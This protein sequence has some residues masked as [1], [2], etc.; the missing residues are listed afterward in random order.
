MLSLGAVT[1]RRTDGGVG[2]SD[3]RAG[4]DTHVQPLFAHSANHDGERQLLVDHLRNVAALAR[5]RA[6]PFG[7]GDLAFLAGLWHDAGKADPEWQRYLLESEAGTRTRGSGP[8]HKSAGA[9]LAEDE[10]Q[11]LVGL[12]IQA[13]HGGLPDPRRDHGPWLNE[14]RARRGPVQA[15]EALRAAMPDLTGGASVGL[16]AH[17]EHNQLAAELFL[18]LTYSALVDADSLDTEAHVLGGAPRERGESATLDELWARYEAFLDRQRSVPDTTVNRVRREVHEA[19]MTAA[20]EPPGLFRLTV[21]TGGGKTRS[22]MAFALRHSIEHR[23]RRVVVAVPFTTITQ[24]TAEVYR[25]IFEDGYPDGGRVVLEHHSAAVEGD[26]AED[27]EGPT[28]AAVWQRLAAENWDAPVIVT[29]TVQLFESLFSNRRGKTRKLHNLA[30][31]V[32]ILDEAQALP[33]DLLA[34]IV[35]GLRELT[36]HYGA[37]VVLSTATQP[38]FDEIDEFKDVRAREIIPGHAR[39]FEVLQRVE[40]DFSKTVEPNA[41]PDVASWIRAERSVLT[42]VNTKRHA[43]ELLEALDDPGALHLSTLLC[44]AHRDEVLAEVRRRLA[45]GEPCRVV[46]TQVVEAGVDLD[47]STVLRAEAPLDAIIQAGGRCN[48]EGRLDGPGRVVVFTPPD[49]ASPL[50]VYRS[51]RDIARVVRELPGFD[52]N[53]PATVQRYFKLLF[54]TAVDTDRY[55]IQ[56]LRKSLDFPEVARRFRMIEDDTYDVIVGYPEGE[57]PHI[58]LLL[59]QLRTRERSPRAVLREL[60][61]H[62]VSVYRREADRLIRERWIQEVMPGIG[63][64]LGTYDAVR[65]IVEANPELIF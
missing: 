63:R 6:Q 41:W 46:S 15:L 47:F 28:A 58:E 56:R 21:P 1:T 39:H 17:V 51:G 45:A 24:Q 4:E 7:G 34:P 59:D 13:H 5:G 10:Q 44:R 42:I 65:G 52:L 53:D 19:C 49:P 8:D 64:W 9:L 2:M 22:A 40:Y 23:M 20:I 31:S 35:D 16:P 61:P 18:R 25:Q 29:T 36:E 14:H 32:I 3:A 26:P 55:R 38:A 48:R 11:A 54:G 12:L 43:T 30:G 27:D 62:I 57:V 50:G 60:Q 33:Y 37:S